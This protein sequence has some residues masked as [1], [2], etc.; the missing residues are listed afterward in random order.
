MATRTFRVDDLDNSVEIPADNPTT[1]ISVV[2]PRDGF[3]V[4]LDLSDTSFKGLIKV[5][6]KYRQAGTETAHRTPS[7]SSSTP[8]ENAEIRAWA[9]AHGHEVNERGAL[10]RKVKEAY[11]A[12]LAT[13]N[14]AVSAGEQSV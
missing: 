6:A 2:D 8:S 13:L 10:P 5:L 4:S 11:A 7:Q 3:T 1:R 12:H 14:A 9:L